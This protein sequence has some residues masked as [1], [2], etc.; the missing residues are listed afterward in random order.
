[1]TI[2]LLAHGGS[3]SGANAEALVLAAAL[4]VV[5][6]A[7]FVQKSAKPVVSVALVLAGIGLAAGGFTF[8][9]GE[10]RHP[11]ALDSRSA[12]AL[13]G[14]CDAREELVGDDVE[15][16]GAAF[17]DRSHAPLHDITDRLAERNRAAAADLLEAKEAVESGFEKAQTGR[18]G[19][20]EETSLDPLQRDVDRLIIATV[21][22]VSELGVEV[23]GCD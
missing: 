8:L 15:A 19:A 18:G 14:L 16:A 23:R 22:G 5:G 11:A 9:A 7:L 21:V 2:L 3:A 1:M 6:I 13:R 10:D 4:A 17:F 20:G 12:A